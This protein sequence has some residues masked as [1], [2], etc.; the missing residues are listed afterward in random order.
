MKTIMKRLP[1]G[2]DLMET[3]TALCEEENITKGSV[4]VIGAVEKAVVSYYRQDER[5][6]VDLVLDQHLEIL[7]GMGNISLKDGKPFVHLH[8][9]LSKESGECLGG[10]AMPG[11]VIFASEAIITEVEGEPLER[12]YDEP[13][14]LF[15]W[16][17]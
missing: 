2:A 10:H 17:E 16:K 7:S 4:Q 9:V 1:K 13:T 11:I 6:Y 15:L 12:E 3:L 5:K 8:V 14:G